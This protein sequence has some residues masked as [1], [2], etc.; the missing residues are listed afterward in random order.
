MPGGN[1]ELVCLLEEDMISGSIKDLRNLV[2]WEQK[3]VF[4]ALFST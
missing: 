1:V 3:Y 4:S 2:W